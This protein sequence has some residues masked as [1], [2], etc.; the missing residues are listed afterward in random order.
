MILTPITCTYKTVADCDIK[1]DVYRQ[2]KR[3]VSAGTIVYIHGGCLIYGSRQGI[4]PRQMALYQEAGYTVVAM[5]YRL[6]PETKLPEIIEDLQAAFRWI[7]DK[8]P[9]LFSGDPG[10][11]AVVGHS[12]G[13]Y[14]ALMAGCYAVPRPKAVVAFYGY[15]D[16]VVPS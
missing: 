14:L 1:V 4:N 12:A 13:G 10:Q 6:A 2:A 11:I 5:D 9:D 7:G 3:A 15:G 8:G 16:I